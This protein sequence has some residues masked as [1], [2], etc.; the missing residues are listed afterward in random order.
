[1]PTYRQKTAPI[2]DVG[3]KDVTD[4]ELAD[5]R[6]PAQREAE[7][8]AGEPAINTGTE[9]DNPGSDAAGNVSANKRGGGTHGGRTR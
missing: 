4:R 6:G 1:M 2:K 8:R 9:Q 3:G 5:N 7:R